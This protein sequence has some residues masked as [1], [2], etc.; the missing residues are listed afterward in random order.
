MA[1][2]NTLS[3]LIT[4]VAL[5]V[6][7]AK[8]HFIVEAPMQNEHPL[9]QASTSICELCFFNDAAEYGQDSKNKMCLMI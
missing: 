4:L 1:L 6:V 9:V 2:V 5:G 3:K 7:N 8:D